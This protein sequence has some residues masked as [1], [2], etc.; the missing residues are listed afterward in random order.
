MG[1]SVT[2]LQGIKAIAPLFSFFY[3]VQERRRVGH[4]F[5]NRWNIII[6]WAARLVGYRMLVGWLVGQTVQLEVLTPETRSAANRI[7]RRIMLLCVGEEF[8]AGA[9]RLAW[10]TEKRKCSVI[11][12]NK[13][14][15]E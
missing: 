9:A 3:R 12:I 10:N 7:L 4:G 13:Q 1:V 11:Y 15:E 5:I 14:N 8:V 6:V 2:C